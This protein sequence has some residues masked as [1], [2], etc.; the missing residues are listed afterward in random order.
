[1]ATVRSILERLIKAT[2]TRVYS[3]NHSLQESTETMQH[4]WSPWRSHYI[5]SFSDES[6]QAARNVAGT[7]CFLC[8][9][10]AQP[11][12]DAE[13]LVVARR[14]H[15]F[16]IM[17]RYPYNA[18]HIMVAPNRHVG[19]L[20]LLSNDELSSLMLTLRESEQM[21]RSVFNPHALNI[22]AN[23]GREAGAGLPD[24][25]HFHLVPRWNGDT[26]FMP[27]LAEVRVVSEALQDT[28]AKLAAAF[29]AQPR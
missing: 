29:A 21:L 17:N 25:I 16:V 10:L 23:L 24:H 3:Y 26:N 8:D 20:T 5:Q 6:S 2:E 4:L 7:G 19:S 15:C 12:R 28:Y 1:M 22:G 13:N 9:A 27:V 14:E 18:G 11:E